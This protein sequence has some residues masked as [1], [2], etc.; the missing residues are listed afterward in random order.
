MRFAPTNR[1]GGG[2]MGM[3]RVR[4]RG[5]HVIH[6]TVD[7]E[8]VILNLDTGDYYSLTDVGAEIWSF[9]RR[10]SSVDQIVEAIVQR[11][12]AARVVVESAV[13]SFISELAAETLVVLESKSSGAAVF[14]AVGLPGGGLPF[15]WPRLRKFTD[16][17][18]Y[19]VAS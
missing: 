1:R 7:D 2:V 15:S 3:E 16:L 10:S 13:N 12:N 14:A 17:Q 5:P 6:E 8:V 18:R 9:I 4:V 11:Y 19:I